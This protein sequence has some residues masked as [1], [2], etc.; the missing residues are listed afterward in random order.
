MFTE[1]KSF[2]QGVAYDPLGHY[3]ATI[4]CDRYGGRR[5]HGRKYLLDQQQYKELIY[6]SLA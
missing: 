2:V 3:L 1:H 6:Y 4:S 5:Q